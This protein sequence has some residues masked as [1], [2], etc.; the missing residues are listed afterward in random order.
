MDTEFDQPVDM[1]KAQDGTDDIY[2]TE[3]LG[4]VYRYSRGDE[5]TRLVLDLTSIVESKTL[6]GLLGLDF[7]PQFP[8]SSYFYVNYTAEPTRP[9]IALVSR[10]SRFTMGENDVADLDS[11]YTILQLDQPG[12]YHNLGDVAFGPDGYLYVPSGDGSLEND[13]YRAAQD[14][15]SR[16]GKL[17]RI[18]VDVPGDSLNYSIPTDNPYYG[19]TDTL[20]A[21]WS[22]GLRNPRQLSFDRKTE[23]LWIGDI[24]ALNYQE[25]N[26][27]AAGNRGGQNYG[28]SCTEG[29]QLYPD[30]DR[31]SCEIPR[32]YDPP[33]F[34]Y[35]VS[36]ND[37]VNGAFI[38]GG[39]VYRGP[40]KELDGYFFFGD[41][42]GSS[43]YVYDTERSDNPVWNVTPDEPVS[44]ISCF[45]ESNDGS[46]F[47]ASYNGKIFRIEV[48]D[49]ISTGRVGLS[50]PAR[51][52]L[53]PNPAHTEVQFELPP[54]G[55]G[56]SL[57]QL[58]SGTGRELARWIEQAGSQQSLRLSLPDVP[59]GLYTLQVTTEG[60]VAAG[61]LIIQ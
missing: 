57:I 52:S 13:E 32:A 29:F 42:L 45:G 3:R 46:M 2:I 44:N 43:L 10:I 24:G 26:Y 16:L 5:K 59:T 17:L 30:R 54:G 51:L 8:D 36:G 18:D 15:M 27:Q 31:A 38:V 55:M 6:G 20:Q 4:K 53:F 28:W 35:P 50:A 40:V 7:H 39:Y 11:E 49:S 48:E 37:G 21:I 14:P 22:M 61:R 33:R 23:D 9:G 60:R 19:S 56:T 58:L 25:M 34:A 12:Q 41:F 1:T 47:V